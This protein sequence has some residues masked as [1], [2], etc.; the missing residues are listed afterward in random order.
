[1]IIDTITNLKK[2]IFLIPNINKVVNF[3]KSN[4]LRSLSDGIYE[5][6][7]KIVYASVSTICGKSKEQAK[8]ET[9]DKMIDI[10]I[11]LTDVETMGFIPRDKLTPMPYSEENDITFYDDIPEQFINVNLGE[12]AIFFQQDGHAPGISN[13]KKLKKIVFKVQL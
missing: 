7:G 10:Q 13:N 9:H 3:I 4:D 8:I 12:F 2:Y 1:M 6:D 5:I 11:P